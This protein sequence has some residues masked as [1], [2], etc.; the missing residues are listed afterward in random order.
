M[1]GYLHGQ[2]SH[3]EHTLLP[4]TAGGAERGTGICLLHLNTC[5]RLGAGA[6][7]YTKAVCMPGQEAAADGCAGG[8]G[9]PIAW[10][11]APPGAAPATE[12][13]ARAGCRGTSSLSQMHGPC[14]LLFPVASLTCLDLQD[15]TPVPGA[16]SLPSGHDGGLSQC[17]VARLTHFGFL[18]GSCQTQHILGCSRAPPD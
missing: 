13:P 2:L 9:P 10:N 14:H 4:Y 15:G 16:E 1:L 8:E 6:W 5:C 11:M 3:W 7:T 17:W 12:R 18:H